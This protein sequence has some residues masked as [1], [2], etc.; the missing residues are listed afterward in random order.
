[1]SVA[2][3]S[4][5]DST[6][7][8]DE[9]IEEAYAMIGGQAELANDAITA[10]RSLNLLLT[11]WQ[12]RGVLLWGTD[13]ASLTLVAGTAE[14][15]LNSDTIDILSGYIRLATNS[16]DFQMTRVG[17]EEYEGITN[18]A[19]TGRPTQFAT[20]KGRENVSVYFFPAPDTSTTYTF[21]HYRMKR[22]KDVNKSGFQNADIP[23]RF[24]PCLTC[25]LAYYL[26][27]K[28][29]QIPV[30]RITMLKDKY[31]ALLSTALLA[32]KERVNLFITPRLG[33]V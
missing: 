33:I 11:D 23:F 19:T 2:T 14:Y 12:N 22:L 17:Y 32:D 18:K 1:M 8:I 30:E 6:F 26:S 21:R 24:L 20:L 10:R 5:F 15:I 28:R 27:Y 31:E 13:L 7:F 4:D 29:P 25:G 16:N 3:T 9:V